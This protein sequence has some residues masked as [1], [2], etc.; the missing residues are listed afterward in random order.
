MGDA[1][2]IADCAAWLKLLS[3]R[4][5]GSCGRGCCNNEPLL[6]VRK[7]SVLMENHA[8]RSGIFPVLIQRRPRCVALTR[9]R[10]RYLTG[11]ETSSHRIIP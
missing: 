6:Q 9:D 7:R 3:D 4:P 5:L 8:H 11:G 1:G 10:L 2:P